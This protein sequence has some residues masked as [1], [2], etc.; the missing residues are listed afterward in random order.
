MFKLFITLIIIAK[1]TNNNIYNQIEF[2]II[3]IY[4]G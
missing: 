1:K 4:M 2:K 3:I